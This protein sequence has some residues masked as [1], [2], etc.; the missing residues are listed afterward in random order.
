MIASLTGIVQDRDDQSVV[1]DVHGVGFRVRTTPKIA[2]D[3][4][5]GQSVVLLTHFHVREDA[6]EIFGFVHQ[7][8]RAM[9]ERLLSVSGVGPKVALSLLGALSLEHVTQAIEQ[10]NAAI[11]RSVAGVGSKTA[12]RIIIDLRGKVT[13]HADDQGL[14]D[15]VGALTR[16]GYSAKEARDVARKVPSDGSPE[17]RLKAALRLAGK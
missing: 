6:M 4:I 13:T 16:L 10:G 14:D 12:E 15:I 7:E 1:I 9:F 5:I 8:E 2:S 11:L 3:L 17:E